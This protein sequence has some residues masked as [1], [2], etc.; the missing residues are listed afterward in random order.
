MEKISQKELG[1]VPTVRKIKRFENSQDF[2]GK[3]MDS[4]CG[5]CARWSS[6]PAHQTPEGFA[7]WEECMLAFNQSSSALLS[8][9]SENEQ[10]NA[11][12]LLNKLEKAF[13][14]N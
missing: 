3:E 7:V 1:G 2:I 5:C 8:I 13:K 4:C 6:D 11:I 12:R 10:A 14:R 9:L